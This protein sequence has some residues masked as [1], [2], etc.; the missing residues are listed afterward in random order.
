MVVPFFPL[1]GIDPM[2]IFTPLTAGWDVLAGLGGLEI[3]VVLDRLLQVP[4]RP[5]SHQPAPVSVPKAA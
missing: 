1:V 5:A 4:H 2:T 3:A